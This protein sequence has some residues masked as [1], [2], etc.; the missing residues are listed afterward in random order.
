MYKGDNKSAVLSQQLIS[1]ALLKLMETKAYTD[2]SIS[3][4]C[5]EAKVSRQTFYSLFGNKE[6]VI[7]YAL[8]NNCR[9]TPVTRIGSCHSANFRTFCHGYSQYIID[10]QNILRILVKN[11]MMH[12]L[13]DVQYENLMTCKDFMDGIT[14]EERIYL[15]DFIASGMN[16]IARNYILTG[17]R[18]D[19]V[20][21]E[22]IMYKLF[23][24]LFF[25]GSKKQTV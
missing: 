6:N 19:S 18:S 22:K 11:D 24:G 17:C 16:S 25:I 1:S 12:C 15:I 5:K 10:R 8:Q 9:Y 13:Y 21:L 7:I 4:M 20:Y 2:I 3:E 14:G 23:G